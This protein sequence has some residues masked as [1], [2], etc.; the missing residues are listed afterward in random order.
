MISKIKNKFKSEDSKKLLSNFVALLSM[1]GLNYILPLLTMPYL[2]RVLGAE[3]FGLVAFA[4]STIMFLN[5]LVEY[6]FNLSATRDISTHSKEKKKLI[7]IYSTVLSVKFILFIV[8]F[9]ILTMLIVFFDKFSTEY[10]LFYLTFLVVIGN[11]LF[12]VWFFQGIEEMKYISYLNIFAKLFFTV[13][14]FIFV[15]DSSDYLYP[16]LLNGIGIIFIGICSIYFIKERYQIAFEY[17][18]S[19]KIKQA[20]KDG[21]N[22]FLTELMPNM[23]NNFSTFFLGFMTTMENVGL[24]ALAVNIIDVFNRFIYIMRN[25]TYPYLNKN[26]T[27]FNKISTI[28]IATGA[29]LS[30]IIFSIS[31]FIVPSIFGEKAYESIDLIY[32]LAL[33]PLFFSIT[34]SY[35]SNKLLIFKKDKV[36]RN[37]IFIGSVYGII[38]SLILI[39]FFGIFGAAINIIITRALIAYLT[40]TKSKGIDS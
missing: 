26:F 35:G 14:I 2:F 29:I 18:S 25:V 6:G 16:P 22:I 33:S 3:K 4:L 23:Y 27:K 19:S 34:L 12:P 28:I 21:W 36:Y 20:F 40:Y 15:N 17:Q 37:I 9:F 5:V 38:S 11:A 30:F 7:E 8:S 13:G 1:Q 24:Y 39:P 32:I 31:Y 10:E